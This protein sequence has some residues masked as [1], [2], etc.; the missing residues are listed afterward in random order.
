MTTTKQVLL[1]VGSA[2]QEGHSTSEALGAYLVAQLAAHGYRVEKQHVHRTLRTPQRRQELL[3]AVDQADLLILA[4][5]LYVDCLPYLVT[6]ALELIAAHRQSQ[7]APRAI[8]FVAIANCGFPEAQH[9]ATALAICCE[10]ARVAQFDWAGGLALGQGGAVGGGALTKRRSMTRN[11][12]A[13]LDLA[14]D[15][16]AQEQPIPQSAVDLMAKPLMPAM[17]YRLM[18]NL[19]WLLEARKQRVVRQLRARPFG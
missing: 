13:A 3:T 1:L 14:A 19:G 4:F 6:D 17:V 8:R 7:A 15:A 5:P 2:K 11:I 10:F 18:G 16:L 9:N 12:T